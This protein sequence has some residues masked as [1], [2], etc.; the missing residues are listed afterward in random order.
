MGSKHNGAAGRSNTIPSRQRHTAS[1]TSIQPSWQNQH[2][3][4]ETTRA[5]QLYARDAPKQVLH[6][7]HQA[8]L[9]P[10]GGITGRK[11]WEEKRGP[12]RNL[13]ARQAR[14]VSITAMT[15]VS[16]LPVWNQNGQNRSHPSAP[17]FSSFCSSSP[18]APATNRAASS[19][20]LSRA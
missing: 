3:Q 14:P 18:S 12:K 17:S 9:R 13:Q 5:S 11:S 1:P 7:S 4:T 2:K 19:Y 6:Q 20:E 8:S 16:L 15:E 10:Q